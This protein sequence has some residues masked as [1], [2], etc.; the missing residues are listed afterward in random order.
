ML[1]MLEIPKVLSSEQL[2]RVAK[3]LAGAKFVDGKLLPFRRRYYDFSQRSAQLRRRR[4]GGGAP[5]SVSRPSSWQ[6][7]MRWRTPRPAC[8]GYAKFPVANDW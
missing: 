2:A 5:R 7:A 8:T 4:A 3:K 1:L 6:P